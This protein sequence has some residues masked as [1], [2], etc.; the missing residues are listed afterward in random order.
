MHRLLRD[1][2]F[3]G[4]FIYGGKIYQGNH[5]AIITEEE[6]N[7]IQDIV[8][9]RSK[10]RQQKHDF[11]L[12]GIIKC[13]ECDYRITAEEHTK[14]YKNGTSQTFAY[15]HCTKKGKDDNKKCN[16]AYLSTTKLEG[17]FATELSQLEF[18]KEAVDLVFEILENVKTTDNNVTKDSYE[19]LQT[20]LEGINRRINNLVGLKISPDNS[21]GSLLSDLEFADR[22]R[23][24]LIEKEKVTLQLSKIDPNSSDWA[25]IGKDSFNFAVLAA[26]RFGKGSSED[27][28][29]I[30]NTIGSKPILLDR[31]LQ[32]QLQYLF[33]KYKEGIKRS[34]KEISRL[35]PKIKAPEQANLDS[36]LKSSLWC[37]GEDSNLHGF[38]HTFLKR[39]R[40]PFRH[41]G[42]FGNF[43]INKHR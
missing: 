15:Y 8:D 27:K 9:G 3:T 30:F 37:R 18:D 38:P 11:A 42:L 33:F 20:V 7:L 29:V 28:K 10:A 24:L 17:Q 2:F 40:I 1:P 23:A 41:L 36:Y 32:F 25:E 34:K 26:K 16:Q 19:A 13:G 43:I 12:N 4:K 39:T 31:N 6:F 14:K 35:V 5:P 21:D 22:K